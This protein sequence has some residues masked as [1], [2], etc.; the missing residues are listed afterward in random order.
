MPEASED[1]ILYTLKSRGAQT[2][3]SLAERLGMTSV[4]ARKHLAALLGKDL[5]AFTDRREQVGRPRRY[6]RLSETGHARFPDAHSDL[7]LEL[8]TSVRRIFGEDGLDR[9]ITDRER[10]SETAYLD[11]LQPCADLEERVAELA[12]IRSRE[13]YMA[14]WE[15]LED[16]TYQLAENHC[17]ICAAAREC[18]G[19]CR[20]E[21]FIFQAVLGPEV[22]VERV[23]HILAGARRCAYRIS[24]KGGRNG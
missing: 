4:G 15:R 20:S 12:A 5:V 21:L 14:E 6:W 3:A 23:E 18:Q 2:A 16:G 7:T 8:L 24:A 17:P 10:R 19:L 9:L 11:A 1:R 13:G 22:N